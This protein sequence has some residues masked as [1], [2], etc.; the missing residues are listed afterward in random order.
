[1]GVNVM[2]R[3]CPLAAL[4]LKKEVGLAGLGDKMMTL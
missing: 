2:S 1:V 4:N 3:V